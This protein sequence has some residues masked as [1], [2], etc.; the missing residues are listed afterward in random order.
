[1]G[2]QLNNT[3]PK[4]VLLQLG[5]KYYGL[6]RGPTRCSQVEL[7]PRILSGSDFYYDEDYLQAFA[8][9]HQIGWNTTRPSHIAGLVPDPATIICY[10]LAMYAT[11]QK[12][13][14]QPL[15]HA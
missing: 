3:I 10:P 11:V 9:K 5:A 2:L 12:Y 7:D 14:N 15:E 6:H 1:M 4:C 13:L 8:K